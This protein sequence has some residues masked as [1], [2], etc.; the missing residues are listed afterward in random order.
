MRL[1]KATD[2]IC[3]FLLHIW[4]MNKWDDI[5]YFL[6]IARARSVRGAAAA[7]DVNPSTVSRRIA[8]FEQSLDVRLFDRLP[9]GYE[10]TPAG[11][12]MLASAIEVEEG[13]FRFER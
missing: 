4:I 13:V 3:I 5:R 7:L 11:E 8:A 9:S 12:A 6:A 2:D 1:C 10:L